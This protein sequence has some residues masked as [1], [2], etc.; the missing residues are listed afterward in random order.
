MYI[1]FITVFI[2]K[3]FM[4]IDFKNC[5][6]HSEAYIFKNAFVRQFSGQAKFDFRDN[7]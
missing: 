2:K 4:N 1:F 3:K 7:P 6:A 5:E